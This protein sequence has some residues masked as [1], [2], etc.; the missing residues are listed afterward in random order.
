MAVMIVTAT[1]YHAHSENRGSGTDIDW[2][3]INH[4]SGINDRRGLDIDRLLH[5]DW[6]LDDHR[7][8]LHD[9]LLRLRNRRDRLLDHGGG[10]LNWSLSYDYLLLH[11]GRLINDRRCGLNDYGRGRHNGCRS[12]I[13][14][15]W[16]KR[17]GNE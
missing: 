11:G 12:Y 5:H 17:F 7:L 9:D 16:F 14:R 10:C 4:R 6:L 13:N 8:L 3:G 1:E 2:R 15:G